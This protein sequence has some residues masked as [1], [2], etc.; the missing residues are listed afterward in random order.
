[1]EDMNF[2]L[3]RDPRE[4]HSGAWD[5][6]ASDPR[7]NILATVLM[8]A[9]DGHF[10]GPGSIFAYRPSPAGDAVTALA[11]RTP[12]YPMLATE[13]EPVAADE[14]I[15]SWLIADPG[16]PGANGEPRTARALAA[17]WRGQTGGHSHV[18]RAM[19]MHR[20]EA[21]TDPRRPPR[22]H[23]RLADASER[24]LLSDWWDAFAREADTVGGAHAALMVDV[25]MTTDDLFVWDDDGPVSLVST[26]PTVA[27][28]AR[29]GPV[30]TPPERRRRGY[31]GMAVAEVSRRLL[32]RDA[33]SCMLFTDLDNPTSNKIYAEVGYRRFGDWEEQVFDWRGPAEP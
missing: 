28:V 30:Y 23:L 3:I 24:D 26:A 14:L 1:M 2:V 8:G 22:G 7:Y 25:R 6:V 11:L 21:V 20:L 16:V 12:P 27:G 15:A 29:I 19:A 32:A 9:L 17:A 5:L 13:L 4:L 31:A 33:H 10:G 18:K